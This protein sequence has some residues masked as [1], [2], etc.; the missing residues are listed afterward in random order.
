ALHLHRMGDPRCRSQTVPNRS[1]IAE[2]TPT[3][4]SNCLRYAPDIHDPEKRTRPPSTVACDRCRIAGLHHIRCTQN[5]GSWPLRSKKIIPCKRTVTRDVADDGPTN[6]Q[7]DEHWF[8]AD[9]GTN[10]FHCVKGQPRTGLEIS[11]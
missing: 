9:P 8:E 7:F 10:D 11:C 5:E 4:S 6:Q 2:R 3:P 1:R